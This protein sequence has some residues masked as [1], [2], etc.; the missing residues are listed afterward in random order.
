MT[1]WEP[2]NNCTRWTDR[3]ENGLPNYGNARAREE[4]AE[5]LDET[6]LRRCVVLQ[7]E[8]H[9]FDM[10]V[11]LCYGSILCV[12]VFCHTNVVAENQL[13]EWSRMVANFSDCN[14]VLC[15]KITRIIRNHCRQTITL[16]ITIA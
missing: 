16:T 10:A 7:L 1:I 8:L 12:C 2:G 6:R 5:M 3:T 11:F 9:R 4:A 15:Q 14:R 13:L